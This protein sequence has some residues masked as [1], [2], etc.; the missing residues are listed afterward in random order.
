MSTSKKKEL[1]DDWQEGE[2]KEVRHRRQQSAHSNQ[3]AAFRGLT[4][5][6]KFF[7]LTSTHVVDQRN[8][9]P[10]MCW[11]GS[12][13][14]RLGSCWLFFRSRLVVLFF[15]CLNKGVILFFCI[16]CWEA[17]W[18]QSSCVAVEIPTLKQKAESVR[19]MR[20]SPA[21]SLWKSRKTYQ[22][23]SSSSC[24]NFL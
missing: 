1:D 4:V 13:T 21:P 23:A 17:L 22:K 16:S 3:K 12:W 18:V 11:S 6:V 9:I 24:F 5:V 20:S 7:L 10:R 2:S 14:R 8:G 15:L 19:L